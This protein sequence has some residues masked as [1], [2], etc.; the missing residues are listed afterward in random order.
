MKFSK[1]GDGYGLQLTGSEKLAFD[2]K[3]S[4]SYERQ[5]L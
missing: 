1:L 3:Q 5:A 4:L 2:L